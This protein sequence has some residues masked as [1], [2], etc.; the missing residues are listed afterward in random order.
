VSRA[1]LVDRVASIS[2]VAV[3]DPDTRAEVLSRVLD[4]A[5]GLPEP[6]PLPHSTEVFAAD[7]L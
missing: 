3:L 1:H 7:R 5:D 4:A 6:I 2:Y